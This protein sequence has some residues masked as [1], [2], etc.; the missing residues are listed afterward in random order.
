[1]KLPTTLL[2]TL[3]L[4]VASIG[5]AGCGSATSNEPNEP[6]APTS[7]SEP[8]A[9]SAPQDP[10]QNCGQGETEVEKPKNIPDGCPWCGRG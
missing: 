10:P 6:S 8:K 1:M 2:Q 9:P 5:V 3:A 7:V 4:A